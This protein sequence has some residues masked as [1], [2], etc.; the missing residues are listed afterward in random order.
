MIHLKSLR[1][2]NFRSWK[3]LELDN[4]DSQ[5]LTLI[6]G[7]NGSGKS[8]L[9]QAIE[10]LLLDTTSDNVPLDEF[11]RDKNTDC[12][13]QCV[14]EKD[15]RL[16][17]ITKYR[18]HSEYTN[19]TIL[20]IDGDD[21]LTTSD[22]RKTQE[23]IEE[24][25]GINRDNIF[26]STIFSQN[27][28]SFGEA[29]ETKRKDIL[30]DAQELS[31]YS[32]YEDKAKSLAAN[33][34]Q[35]IVWN[36]DK[37]ENLKF[38]LKEKKEKI[39]LIEDKYNNFDS[40]KRKEIASLLIEKQSLV[41]EDTSELEEALKE[42]YKEVKEEVSQDR[43]NSIQEK[44]HNIKSDIKYSLT[45]IEKYQ[46][47]MER[48]GDGI[49]PIFKDTCGRLVEER[50]EVVSEF[51][52]KIELEQAKVNELSSIRDK[53]KVK[54]EAMEDLNNSIQEENERIKSK[55]NNLVFKINEVEVRNKIIPEQ[56]NKLDDRIKQLSEKSNPY[57]EIID[58]SKNEIE[59]LKNNINN[60]LEETKNLKEDIKYY[61]FWEEGFSKKGIPNI[62]SESFVEE[63]ERKI[64][65]Y[66]STLTKS[67]YVGIST[68]AELKSKDVREKIS[69]K[70]LSPD[71]KITDYKSYSGGERQRVKVSD[72]F[73][74]HDLIG[75][76]NFIILD[77]V[78]ELSLD[79]VGKSEV[80]KLLKEKANELGSLFVISHDKQV[81]N[82]FDNV[83]NIK[84]VDGVST[85]RS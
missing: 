12:M 78:L 39:K 37:V 63:L 40:E 22:R 42:S 18:N 74:F 53:V 11:P 60:I 6:Q 21:S 8:S 27:S 46:R 7:D 41:E 17:T 51:K 20:D 76:M 33:C 62:L 48:V 31:K 83:I 23:K 43:I 52:P 30:Y 3:E 85:L 15:N 77:E 16:I 34:S 19:K 5:G 35:R 64:N 71:S 61:S 24:V 81:Q 26:I 13:L 82:M 38:T 4:L 47:E 67:L 14:V 65:E 80:V 10:Y 55:I 25:L 79:V 28:L 68:Q 1:L 75:K 29:S 72:I 2:K 57:K 36:E 50:E 73:A 66:L 54:L 32:K 84:K 69:Y 59:S 70:I 56:R 58:D 9:R 44:L 49:C 45:T